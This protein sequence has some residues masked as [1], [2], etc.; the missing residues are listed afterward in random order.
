MLV[1]FIHHLPSKVIFILLILQKPCNEI[2]FNCVDHVSSLV[3]YVCV[4]NYLKTLWLKT[5]TTWLWLIMCLAF[6]G[7]WFVVLHDKESTDVTG[8]LQLVDEMVWRVQNSFL[9]TDVLSPRGDDYGLD[10]SSWDRRHAVELEAVGH[11]RTL[12]IL[13]RTRILLFKNE[14]IFTF[15][16][17]KDI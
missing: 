3:I 9:S 13:L 1:T 7:W 12:S 4:T 8:V 15:R 16:E 2:I 6:S 5:A 17:E 11:P 14:P 10:G